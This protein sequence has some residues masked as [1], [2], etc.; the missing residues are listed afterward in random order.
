LPPAFAARLRAGLL[1]DELLAR[2]DDDAAVL[3]PFEPA[4][5]LRALAP[6]PPDRDR[7]LE[8]R[9]FDPPELPPPEDLPL[10]PPRVSAICTPSSEALPATPRCG[11]HYLMPT[12]DA[13]YA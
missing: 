11:A 3:R 8:L 6:E 1:L 2:D 5:D 13:T 10:L 9:D 7:V 12:A 4:L